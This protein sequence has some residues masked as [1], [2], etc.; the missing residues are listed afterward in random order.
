MALICFFN[1]LCDLYFSN[2]SKLYCENIYFIFCLTYILVFVYNKT[3][4]QILAY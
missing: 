2:K 1:F 3:N 4:I